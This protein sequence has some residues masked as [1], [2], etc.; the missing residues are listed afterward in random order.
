MSLLLRI[1]D[2]ISGGT[3]KRSGI[4]KD[5]KRITLFFSNIKFKI[6]NVVISKLIGGVMDKIIAKII[7]AVIKNMSAEF[8]ENLTQAVLI[9]E[10][11]AKE[12]KNPWDDIGVMILKVALGIN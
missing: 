12:S 10:K 2:Q 7:E 5:C 3:G 1:D 4:I 6:L 9:L 8:R 11:N